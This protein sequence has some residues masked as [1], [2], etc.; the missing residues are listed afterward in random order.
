MPLS[1]SSHF[2]P[3]RGPAIAAAVDGGADHRGRRYRPPWVAVVGGGGGCPVVVVGRAFLSFFSISILLSLPYLFIP[4]TFN[5]YL[6]YIPSTTFP[7]PHNFSLVKPFP[8]HTSKRTKRSLS[9]LQMNVS[10]PIYS[11]STSSMDS[12]YLFDPTVYNDPL[13]SFIHI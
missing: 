3:L 11:H 5:L 2:L 7:F 1:L 10:T 6:L 4:N 9:F 8:L 12:G 13:D